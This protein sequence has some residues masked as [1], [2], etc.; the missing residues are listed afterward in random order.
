MEKS[1]ARTERGKINELNRSLKNNVERNFSFSDY[2]LN[3]GLLEYETLE[4]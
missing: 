1:S 2:E 4:F 3:D